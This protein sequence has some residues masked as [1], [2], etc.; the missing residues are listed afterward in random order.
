MPDA[1]YA[2]I[3]MLTIIW[4]LICIQYCLLN[5]RAGLVETFIFKSEAHT[6][7]SWIISWSETQV[8][9][10]EGAQGGGCGRDA[11]GR[12]LLT[13]RAAAPAGPGICLGWGLGS[14]STVCYLY[15]Y[16]QA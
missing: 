6:R 2:S 14:G 9:P 4:C 3:N 5:C 7:N 1:C 10:A 12:V 16:T 15:N 11:A 8:Q 13:S